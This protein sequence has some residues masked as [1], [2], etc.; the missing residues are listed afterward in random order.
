MDKKATYDDWIA[1]RRTISTS[2]DLTDRVMNSIEMEN[3]QPVQL[4]RVVR[5]AHRMNESRPARW[6]ACTAALCIG[7]LPFLFVAYVAKFLQF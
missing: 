4:G 1:D 3:L 7:F 2:S 5:L 6:A